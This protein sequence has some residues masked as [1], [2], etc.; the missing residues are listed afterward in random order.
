MQTV[1]YSLYEGRTATSTSPL[2]HPSLQ[3]LFNLLKR[4]KPK[5]ADNDVYKIL[6]DIPR[7][8]EGCRN[9]F[10]RPFRFR[11][12]LPPDQVVFNHE[13][14]IDLMWL[15]GNPTLHV[16]DTHTHF[17]NTVVLRSRS[18]RDIWD[19]FVEC[20]ASVYV[21]NPNKMGVDHES[22]IMSKAWEAMRT[23]QGIEVQISGM[24][25][26]NS[27]GAEERY[28]QPL[29]RILRVLRTIHS[30]VDPEVLLRYAIK[31]I[32]DTIGPEGL[33]S[34]L[35]LFGVVPTFPNVSS[36]LPAQRERLASLDA[37]RK[38]METITAELRI[39]TAL[40]A[41]LPPSTRYLIQPG[42]SVLVYCEKSRQYEEP[43]KVS[44]VCDKELYVVNMGVE[45]L[46][47]IAQVLPEP[48]ERGDKELKHLLDGM[49][50]FK[51]GP[52][53]G[54]YVTEVLHPADRRG[55]M[56]LFYEAKDKKLTGLV[57]RGVYEVVCKKDVSKDANILGGR[58]FLAIKNIRTKE[59]VYKARF[60]V[61]G[62]TDTEKNILVHNTT[63]LR[64]GSIRTLIAVAALFGF[65]LWT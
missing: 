56:E 5:K 54:V 14:A 9:H 52:P 35:L 27:I 33:V 48:S 39:E 22:G 31:G 21:G 63:N 32:N 50:Q 23:A 58:F 62:Q 18:T 36:E 29:R 64:R 43:Y 38:E 16:V 53:P 37:A 26:H 59:E 8:C 28:H 3:K 6:Q 1:S 40:R 51:T 61:Q 2:F 55:N 15:E 34:L 49:E 19:G 24:D 44:R 25:S 46:F 30:N 60:V 41:K 10:V 11:A 20:W 17:Q 45:K 47:N 65:R 7:A 12:A 57:E 13:V 42:N 4:A